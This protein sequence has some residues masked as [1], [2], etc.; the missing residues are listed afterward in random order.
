MSVWSSKVKFDQVRLSQFNHNRQLR[1][2]VFLVADAGVDIF[3]AP[4]ANSSITDVDVSENV[5]LEMKLLE[6]SS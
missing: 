6:P 1:G 5:Y 3:R 4:L 2:V